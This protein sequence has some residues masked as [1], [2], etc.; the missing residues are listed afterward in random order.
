MQ[1]RYEIFTMFDDLLLLGK[2]GKTVYAGPINGAALY[3]SMHFKLVVPPLTNPAD[4]LLDWVAGDVPA[5]FIEAYK[6]RAPTDVFAEGWIQEGAVAI[7]AGRPPAQMPTAASPPP[8]TPV[9]FA[10]LIWLTFRR[11]L[12]Q[13]LR[14]PARIALDNAMPVLSA[15]FLAAMY[16]GEP[17]FAA[18]QPIEAFASCPATIGPACQACLFHS[19]DTILNRGVMAIITIGL[20]AVSSYLPVFGAERVVLRR[21][22]AALPQPR[23]VIAYALGKDFAYWPQHMLGPFLF[24]A[25]Y[26]MLAAP[27]ASF[28]RYYGVYATVYWCASGVAYLVSVMAPAGVQQLIGVTIIFGMAMFAGGQPTLAAMRLKAIPLRYLPMFSFM[29]YALEALYVGEVILYDTIVTLQGLDLPSVVAESL[30]FNVHAYFGNVIL[31]VVYGI[32][33]RGLAIAVMVAIAVMRT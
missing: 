14:H 20:A 2:G 8:F 24:T 12:V 31:L 6:G 21:E 29:R 19:Q 18:P 32:L 33:M 25:V 30:G 26:V 17:A 9:S 1:P 22:A 27:R 10:M 15:V 4:A 23:H 11:S 28:W 16:M 13:Q 3:F 7:A 5:E